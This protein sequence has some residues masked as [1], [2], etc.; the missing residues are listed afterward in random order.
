MIWWGTDQVYTIPTSL[1]HVGLLFN[2]NNK[3][4]E[5]T[6]KMWWICE[7]RERGAFS[8]TKYINPEFPLF[9]DSKAAEAY[10]KQ[11]EKTMFGQKYSIFGTKIPEKDIEVYKNKGF[12]IIEKEDH[13]SKETR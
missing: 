2:R 3:P 9:E 7:V 13:N 8:M 5:K 1:E 6:R 12:K 11:L 4:K 10:C